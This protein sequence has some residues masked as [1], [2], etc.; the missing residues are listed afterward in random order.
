MAL[1]P[2]SHGA[3]AAGATGPFG[4]TSLVGRA[5]GRP[6]FWLAVVLVIGAFPIVR[7]L[8]LRLPPPPAP[9]GALPAFALPGPTGELVRY[10]PGKLPGGNDDLSGRV[11]VFDLLPA[12]DPVAGA[13]F[14]RLSELQARLHNLGEA[15]ALVS[16]CSGTRPAELAT[17]AAAHRA[18]PRLWKLVAGQPQEISVAAEAALA[19]SVGGTLGDVDRARL[20]HGSEL[21]LVDPRGRI[22]LAADASDPSAFEALIREAGLVANGVH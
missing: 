12:Q 14:G 13:A 5:V 11:L 19:A 7:A 17:L 1:S 9:L 18:S 22:R 8:V 3:A 6:A 20:A 2:T 4:P 15:F 16:F 21:F 10:A